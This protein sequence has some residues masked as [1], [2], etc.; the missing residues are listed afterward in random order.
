M[1]LYLGKTLIHSKGKKKK[2]KITLKGPLAQEQLYR[3]AFPHSQATYATE[4]Q[5]ELELAEE[6]GSIVH[7]LLRAWEMQGWGGHGLLYQG[8]EGLLRQGSV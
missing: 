6:L 3:K 1:R 2:L 8:P 5:K 4:V 7:T